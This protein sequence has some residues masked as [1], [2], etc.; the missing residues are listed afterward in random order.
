MKNW[1]ACGYF[2]EKES[3]FCVFIKEKDLFKGEGGQDG[4]ENWLF[5]DEIDSFWYFTKFLIF[6]L[7][8]KIML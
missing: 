4:E 1:K 7:F 3:Q 5:I 2:E 6:W 8:L